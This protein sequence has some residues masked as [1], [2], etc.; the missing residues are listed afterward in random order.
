MKMLKVQF[1]LNLIGAIA[2]I[3]FLAYAGC[4]EIEEVDCVSDWTVKRTQL[5]AEAKYEN[6]SLRIEVLNSESGQAIEVFQTGLTGDFTI[7]TVFDSFSPGTGFG[8]YAQLVVTEIDNDSMGISG[9]S[10]GNGMIEAFVAY[11]FEHSDSRFTDLT[12]GS[13]SI[14]RLDSTIT[15]TC[16]V[17][18]MTVSKTKVFS[19]SD[20]KVAFQI[21]STRESLTGNTGITIT[22]FNVS[23]DAGIEPDEFECD[24]VL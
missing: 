16:I 17:G 22:Q 5:T 18:E 10:L 23:K 13:F 20:L 7:T 12:S 4:S 1:V 8:G 21:G 15:S 24:L 2:L 6:G 19:N 9:V 14:E 3:S 11:P